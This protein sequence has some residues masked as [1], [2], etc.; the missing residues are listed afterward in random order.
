MQARRFGCLLIFR[1]STPS[2]LDWEM[3]VGETGLFDELPDAPDD[4]G[5]RLLRLISQANFD[6]LIEDWT[7]ESMELHRVSE[8]SVAARRLPDET[9]GMG[10]PSES[11]LMQALA[12]A[13][14]PVDGLAAS[15]RGFLSLAVSG[16]RVLEDETAFCRVVWVANGEVAEP[17]FAPLE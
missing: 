5:E 6:A 3:S 13:G 9:I 17:V 15:V 1:Q 14:H 12:G 2:G 7:I 8:G 10:S 16:S 11:Q 4:S